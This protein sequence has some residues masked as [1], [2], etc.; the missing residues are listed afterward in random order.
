MQFPGG[1]AVV[2]KLNVAAQH[3]ASATD[4]GS[5]DHRFDWT[6]GGTSTYFNNGISP[7]RSRARWGRS[8]SRSQT[9]KA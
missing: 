9:A 7:A 6:N 1:E 4:A 5:D 2:S 3:K 8:P